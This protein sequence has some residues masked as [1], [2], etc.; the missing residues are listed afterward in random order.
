MPNRE[1]AESVAA[2]LGDLP[3]PGAFRRQVLAKTLP[4]PRS[5]WAGF[6]AV[7][8]QTQVFSYAFWLSAALVTLVAALATFALTRS[9]ALPASLNDAAR[10]SLPLAVVS[11][12]LSAAGVSYAFRSF[13][14]GAW[15]VELSCPI[16]PVTLTVG[17]LLIVLGYVT[18]LAAVVSLV[19]WAASG[20][21]STCL[22]SI[23]ES[24]FLPVLL[25]STLSFYISLRFSPGVGTG[26]C[27]GFWSLQV[28]LHRTWP[29]ASLLVLPGTPHAPGASLVSAILTIL[30]VTVSLKV[31]ASASEYAGKAQ[32]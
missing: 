18:G 5:F 28:L 17:R 6:G 13:G 8:S 30:L 14:R 32:L 26:V 15:E 3:A 9:Q 29:E 11:P 4:R 12:A 1:H 27:L 10:L 24:W 19:L 23:L 20:E 22:L 16:S 21:A 7:R 25:L 2:W 31:A